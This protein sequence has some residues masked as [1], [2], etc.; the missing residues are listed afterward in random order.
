MLDRVRDAEEFLESLFKVWYELLG[1]RT[2]AVHSQ[3]TYD[4]IARVAQ[5]LSQE[6]RTLMADIADRFSQIGAM[7]DGQKEFL[8]GVIEFFQTRTGIHMTIA[9]DRNAIESVRQNDDMRKISAWV[10]IGAVPTAVTGFF[11][12]NVPTPD[13]APGPGSTAPSSPCSSSPRSSTSCFVRAVARRSRRCRCL[14]W[15]VPGVQIRDASPAGGGDRCRC[16]AAGRRRSPSA[17]SGWLVDQSRLER[18]R[19]LKVQLPVG[20]ASQIARGAYWLEGWISTATVRPSPWR[21]YRGVSIE[22]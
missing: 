19:S 6:Q 10:V 8:H 22:E 18:C 21:R 17:C 13:S 2:I 15:P 1:I 9:A 16:P 7:A 5:F 3:V 20:W 14:S 11:G 12:Q 4:R